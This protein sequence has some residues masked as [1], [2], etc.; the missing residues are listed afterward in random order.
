MT[1]I[2]R[3]QIRKSLSCLAVTDVS[4]LTSIPFGMEVG[5]FQIAYF[6][7]GKAVERFLER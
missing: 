4:L 1:V 3:T 7:E 6:Y 5:H 2:M